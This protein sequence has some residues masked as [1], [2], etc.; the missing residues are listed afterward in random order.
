MFDTLFIDINFWSAFCG[1]LGSICIFF[2]GLPPKI[3]SDGLIGLALEQEDEDGKVKGKI[4]KYLSYVGLSL[5][6]LSFIL[7]IIK[8]I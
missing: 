2:F 5:L 6:A 4:Y 7:Q 3:N 1:F 8:L